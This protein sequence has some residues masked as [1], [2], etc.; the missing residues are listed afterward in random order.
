MRLVDELYETAHSAREETAK[1]VAKE[2][3]DAF[4]K[5]MRANA[6]SGSYVSNLDDSS[7]VL[8]HKFSNVAIREFEKLL[9]DE[10]IKLRINQGPRDEVSYYVDIQK[11]KSEQGL[12]K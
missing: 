6:N 11:D 4:V 5:Q 3:F 8:R 12:V 7:V 9:N 10:G 1:K 2:A